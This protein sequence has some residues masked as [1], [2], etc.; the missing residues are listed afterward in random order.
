MAHR[1]TCSTARTVRGQRGR[2][3]KYRNGWDS[4]NSRISVSTETLVEWRQIRSEHEFSSDNSVAVYL[5]ECNKTQA[6]I[7]ATQRTATSNR[8]V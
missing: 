4:A 7:L 2:P 5:L 3:R 6:N 8:L 1:T